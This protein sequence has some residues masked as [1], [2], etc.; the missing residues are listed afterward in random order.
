MGLVK[1]T[2][3]ANRAGLRFSGIDSGALSF[4]DDKVGFFGATP[5]VQQAAI[6]NIATT[7]TTGSLPT[8]NSAVVIA[9]TATP[10]VVELL[11]YCVE[12]ETKLESVLAALRAVGVIASS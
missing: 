8:P 2:K 11:D 9:N 1:H 6:T 12:L 3:P 10:T 7:A 5:V 4:T